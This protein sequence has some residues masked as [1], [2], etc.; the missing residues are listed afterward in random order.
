MDSVLIFTKSISK[1]FEVMQQ[2]LHK[3]EYEASG[4]ILQEILDKY[5]KCMKQL[6]LFILILPLNTIQSLNDELISAFSALIHIYEQGQWDAALN[7]LSKKVL[8]TFENWRSEL[9]RVIQPLTI[10]AN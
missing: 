1:Q 8:S 9:F 4:M 3:K 5:D 6:E 10:K 7:L 2:H